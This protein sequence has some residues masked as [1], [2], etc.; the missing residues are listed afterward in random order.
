MNIIESVH[1]ENS[2]KF[3]LYYRNREQEIR[4]REKC[5]QFYKEVFLSEPNR[6][7]EVYFLVESGAEIR[8]VKN[9]DHCYSARYKLKSEVH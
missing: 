1:F 4:L 5:K 2:V 3:R 8:I 7:L 6:P 9:S